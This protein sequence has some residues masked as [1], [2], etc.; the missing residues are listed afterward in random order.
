MVKIW[1]A[2]TGKL[3][4]ALPIKQ[5]DVKFSP[6][7]KLAVQAAGTLELWD[8]QAGRVVLTLKGHSADI[9]ALQFSRDGRR[10]LTASN[11]KTARVWDSRTGKTIAVMSGHA[12]AIKSV[13]FTLDERQVV[14]WSEDA[15][16][17]L[18]DAETGKEIAA[19]RP[20]P[21]S[22]ST[23]TLLPDGAVLTTSSGDTAVRIWRDNSIVGDVFEGAFTEDGQR[24]VTAARDGSIRVW[25]LSG[26]R[27]REL[28]RLDGDNNTAVFEP[29]GHHVLLASDDAILRW[30]IRSASP[31]VPVI[32]SE[33]K[34]YRAAFDRGARRVAVATGQWPKIQKEML[35]VYD[36]ASG[37]AVA[38][39]KELPRAEHVALSPDGQR[40]AAVLADETVRIWDVETGRE[41]PVLHPFVGSI[42]AGSGMVTGV[43][44]LSPDGRRVAVNH[45]PGLRIGLLTVYDAESGH[46]LLAISD[47]GS[48]PRGITD[49][50]KGSITSIAFS[51]D[52]R[53]LLTASG[54]GGARV[55]DAATGD[56]L[57]VRTDPSDEIVRVT[58]SPNGK[59]ISTSF[60]NHTTRI[61]PVFEIFE[62]TQQ[63]VDYAKQA[64]P[65]CLTQEQRTSAFLDPEPLT[66]C[67]ELAKW[68]YQSATWKEWLA[69]KRAGVNPPLADSAEWKTWRAAH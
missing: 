4:R 47:G 60:K 27:P 55:F 37:K 44:A 53:H 42:L 59:L 34:V 51:P 10:V 23:V 45:S 11:D 18:W 25:D 14:T 15:T 35:T 1:D 49:P 41:L 31:P 43:L 36:V 24:V 69:Y 12:A 68:P 19:P 21:G 30:D 26:A 20:F 58:Y 48:M 16:L 57:T 22:H 64:I 28:I 13:E 67:I 62:T 8:A 17:R 5:Y 39:F 3:V 61:S 33:R 9:T 7:G 32:A 29:D 66:W 52:G 63:L 38:T 40:V 50:N 46:P 2:D 56:L 65:R 54:S 6:D